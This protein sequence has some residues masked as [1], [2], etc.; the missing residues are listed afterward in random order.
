M[1]F[2]FEQGHDLVFSNSYGPV[3]EALTSMLETEAAMQLAKSR[4]DRAPGKNPTTSGTGYIA[5]E[6]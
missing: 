1:S 4:I 2:L 5:P 3:R 6:E